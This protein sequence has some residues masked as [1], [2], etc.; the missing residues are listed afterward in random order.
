MTGH[1]LITLF[2]LAW[3][4]FIYLALGL[5]LFTFVL[6]VFDFGQAL[7]LAVQV[8]GLGILALCG[9]HLVVF[10]L[11][12]FL[13]QVCFA[14]VP[15]TVRWF[16][17]LVRVRLVG[18]AYN[19]TMPAAGL[20][21]E[22]VKV[23]LLHSIYGA[24]RSGSLVSIVLFRIIN[25]FG[26]IL[27][28]ALAF[29]FMA[30]MPAV[31]SEVGTAAI[32][33]FALLMVMAAAVMALPTWRMASRLGRRLSAWRP[34]A[35]FGRMLAQVEGAEAQ[36][37]GFYRN[38]RARFVWAIVLSMTQWLAGA[39]EIWLALWLLGHP[40]GIAE[41]VVIE[42]LLQAVRTASFFVPSNLG[43]QDG[44]IV[45]V[46]SLF[47]G[48]PVAG[49]SAALLRRLRQFIW[50]VSGFLVGGHYSWRAFRGQLRG[51]RETR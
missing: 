45:I 33:G 43:T 29:V 5:V 2:R 47:T 32:A 23:A 36:V 26:Q 4:K 35:A 39:L 15:I 19:D 41:A 14:E 3:M 16:L 30:L 6:S 44:T 46:S 40:I 28:L 42:A 49:L 11:D 50:I 12:V 13:W 37:A 9:A 10:L 51:D 22:P 7:A 25:L 17:R 24:S 38:F 21:G 27:I 8:G 31:T 18:E 20:G 34:T 48:V 1:S